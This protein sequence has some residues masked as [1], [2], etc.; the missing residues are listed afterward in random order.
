MVVSSQME[1]AMQQQKYYP[2]FEGN[3]TISRFFC[4]GIGGDNHVPQYMC[5][6]AG[7]MPFLHGKRNDIRWLVFAKVLP[8]KLS[9]SPV[10]NNRNGQLTF[11]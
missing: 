7:K 4:S 8:V 5:I 10:T 1:D 6:Q 3:V 11:G 2:V 9:N